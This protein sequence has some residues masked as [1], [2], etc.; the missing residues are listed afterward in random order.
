MGWC[1]YKKREIWGSWVAQSVKRLILGFSSGR[2][3]TV[4]EFEPRIGLSADGVEAAWDSLSFPLSLSLH[5]SP[6]CVLSPKNK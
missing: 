3:L 5:P 1:P 4:R 6:T 2:D